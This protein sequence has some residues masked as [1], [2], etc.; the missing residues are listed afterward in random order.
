M[1]VL[2]IGTNE[3]CLTNDSF[4]KILYKSTKD[5]IDY[6]HLI[7][8]IGKKK[9]TI[10]INSFFAFSEHKVFSLSLGVKEINDSITKIISEKDILCASFNPLFKKGQGKE[11][12]KDIILTLIK[13]DESETHIEKILKELLQTDLNLSNIYSF[14]QVIN[15]IGM[16]YSLLNHTINV[17][18]VVLENSAM[19]MVSNTVNFMFGRLIKKREEEDVT[20]T[21]AK[22]L[23][24]TIKYI[25]TTYS[26]LKNEIKITI[27]A[28]TRID[29]D[30]IK[31][32]DNIFDGLR[33]STQILKLPNLKISKD[34]PSLTAE[35]QLLKL[36][37]GNLKY[38]NKMV[39]TEIIAQ[40]NAHKFIKYLKYIAI[41]S[42]LAV[43]VYT[44]YN[45]LTNENLSQ[46]DRNIDRQYNA[47]IQ[48]LAYEE[49]KLKKY[50]NK[51]YA[52]TATEIQTMLNDNKHVDIIKDISKIF[53]K[54]RKLIVVEGYRMSCEKCSLKNRKTTLYIDFALFN[55]NA[56]A[57]FAINKLTELENDIK[58]MMNKKYKNVDISF[59]QLTKEKRLAMVRDVRDTMIISYSNE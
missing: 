46:Q 47:V 11:H 2:Y 6:K 33:M 54:H 5:K 56:S 7:K 55:V 24:T 35:L 8:N 19:I 9:C 36:A 50:N 3:I 34:V 48:K 42:V 4:S 30:L 14:D 23:A 58:E 13:K 31:S 43:I 26:F 20:T 32:T 59:N 21:M 41:F 40:C 37:T 15:T 57:R 12:A 27:M 45:F 51:I 22:M 18:V 1:S 29:I 38:V 17:N 44:A 28:P 39:N 49:N 52:I 16:S 25:N 53:A 10:I